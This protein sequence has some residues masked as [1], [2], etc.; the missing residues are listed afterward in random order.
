M[1]KENISNLLEVKNLSISVKMYGRYKLIVDDLSFNVS[2]GKFTAIIG[3]SGV[4]KSLVLKA[5][6]GFLDEPWWLLKGYIKHRCP[7]SEMESFILY[8]TQYNKSVISELRGNKISAIL[9][10]ADTHL[11]PSFPIDW[12]IGEVL[13][14]IEP[15]KDNAYVRERLRIVGIDP[16]KLYDYPHQFSQ[17]Q[18]QRILM[19][20]TAYAPDLLIAD[21]PTSAL[22][23]RT[24]N[25]IIYVLKKMRSLGKIKTLLMATHDL[26]AVENLL[27]D[28]DTII[29]MEEAGD[30][31]F[32]KKHFKFHRRISLDS[33]LSKTES[34]TA[35][36]KQDTKIPILSIA[37]LE[38][39]Y[40]R[41]F[42]SKKH[43][44]LRNVHLDVF[45]G[46]I[47]GIIGRSGHGKTTLVKAIARL[48]NNTKGEIKYWPRNASESEDLIK[49][50][51]NGLKADGCRIRGL[52]K[53]M[54]IIFQDS[55]SVFN[56]RMTIR[57]LLTETLEIAET[58][59]DENDT[60]ELMK[61][62]LT[63]VGIC[64]D[65]KELA[66]IL[67][68]YPAELSGGE[69]QRLAFVRVAMLK[70]RLV[71]ADEPFAEQDRATKKEMFE[72]ID[73]MRKKDGTTFVICSHDL[74]F[75]GTRCDRWAILEDGEITKTRSCKPSFK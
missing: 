33:L 37:G 4:G 41:N 21:E 59:H 34:A 10:S 22:D 67:A 70:P 17:G 74:D 75:I 18:R 44:V 7:V 26:A 30:S 63:T 49:L 54:Q 72:L 9:Q 56:P 62:Y 48:I 16:H 58:E 43:V 14:P 52:R 66:S 36:H 5:I 46:E 2:K 69:R 45:K 32:V 15:R 19:A 42:F 65:P 68:K 13:D 24:K 71:I 39:S 6:L 50:Q 35:I 55:S 38:Q 27:E 20:M 60:T 1:P 31:L 11:H 23:E 53:D 12:Q 25:N 47:L 29:N 51:P 8:N 61:N 28:D 73:L 3:P 40:R 57:E 64:R